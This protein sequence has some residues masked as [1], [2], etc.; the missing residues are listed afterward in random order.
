MGGCR[1]AS[2]ADAAG[3]ARARALGEAMWDWGVPTAASVA[4]LAPM[5]FDTLVATGGIATGLD[6]A[7][8]IALGAHAAGIARPV[9][10]ALSSE[11]RV[12]AVAYLDG[13]DRELR[14]TMLL[15]GAAD[16]ASMRRV[17][18]VIVGELAQWTAQLSR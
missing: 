2:R 1:D 15:T 6:V 7:R 8:A 5:G 10:R 11:G 3:D 13:V 4:L 12:G 9:L 18:R 14:A 17:P 16:V